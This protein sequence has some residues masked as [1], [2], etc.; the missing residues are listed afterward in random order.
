M[1]ARVL[2]VHLNPASSALRP[3]PPADAHRAAAKRPVPETL[4]PLWHPM[5][6]L[7]AAGEAPALAK[8]VAVARR[9]TYRPVQTAGATLHIAF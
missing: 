2:R 5:A 4:D 6:A 1:L 8:H 9:F 7:V 3:T